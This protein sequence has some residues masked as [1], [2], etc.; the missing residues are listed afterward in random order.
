VT[1]GRDEIRA[2][3]RSRSASLR[4]AVRVRGDESSPTDELIDELLDEPADELLDEGES[5]A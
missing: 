4:T 5:D 1:A 2:N 3:R